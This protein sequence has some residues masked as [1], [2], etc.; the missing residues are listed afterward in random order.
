[1]QAHGAAAEGGDGVK[2]IAAVLVGAQ[3]FLKRAAIELAA[4]HVKALPPEV[5]TEMERITGELRGLEGAVYTLAQR[6]SQAK[7]EAAPC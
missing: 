7:R 4:V 1:M 2:Q 3:I 6:V 5:G